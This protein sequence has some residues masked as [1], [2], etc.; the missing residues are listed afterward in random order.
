M[1]MIRVAGY[2][3]AI[4]AV[5]ALAGCIVPPPHDHGRGGPSRHEMRDVDRGPHGGPPPR[6]DDGRW[7]PPDNRRGPP[8]RY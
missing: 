7:G 1:R 4:A 3:S 8:P 5:S 6:R 2:V